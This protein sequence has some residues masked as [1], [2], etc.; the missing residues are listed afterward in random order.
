MVASPLETAILN[1]SRTGWLLTGLG[2]SPF[3][4]AQPW[5][6]DLIPGHLGGLYHW[7]NKVKSGMWS[8]YPNSQVRITAF[9]ATPLEAI[10]NA[11]KLLDKHPAKALYSDLERAFED[12]ANEREDGST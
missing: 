2:K 5:S 3:D 4:G 8:T 9:G 10:H 11:R 1:I 7:G 6:C 12:A